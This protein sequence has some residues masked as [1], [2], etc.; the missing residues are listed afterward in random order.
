MKVYENVLELIGNT[1]LIRLRKMSEGTKALIYGKA[2]HLNPTGSVKDRIALA[3]IED[4]EAKGKLKPG[5][6]VVEA[7]GGNTG[8]GLAMVAASKGYRTIFTM[9]DKMSQEKVRFLKSLGAQVVITPSAVPPDSPEYYLNTAKRIHE[10]TANSIYANQFYNPINPEI[11]YQRTGPEIWEQSE[12]KINYFVA[13]M[14]T[15]GTISGVGRYL[16]E[17]NPEVKVIAADPDGSI[18]KDYFYTKRIIEARPWKVEGIGEDMIP[19]NH[20]YQYIDEVVQVSDKESFTLARRLAREEGILAGG[21]SGTILGAALK[22]ARQLDEP[23][24]FVV[25]LCDAGDR[26]L[27]KCHSDEWMKENQFLDEER[28]DQVEVDVVLT[29]KSTRLPAL[30]HVAPATL[31][32]DAIDLMD[33]YNISQIPVLDGNKAVGNITEGKLTRRVLEDQKVLGWAV[34]EVMEPKLPVLDANAPVNLAMKVL[35]RD[36][37]ALLVRRL[38]VF[39]GVLTRHDLIEFLSEQRSGER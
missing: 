21:S 39:V 16:K 1:P 10:E 6:V 34:S 37:S 19:P 35:T 32:S 15:G 25:V 38:G 33:E 8:L 20:H 17:Q 5:G 27:S 24:M 22:V 28:P 26:Y 9:P 2:E 12:G 29:R 23:K 13:G 4:A 36:A 18:I 3:I 31:V 14:G 30:V 7:T 11:H